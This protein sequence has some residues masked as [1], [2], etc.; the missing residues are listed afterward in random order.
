[1]KTMRAVLLSFTLL[2]AAGVQAADYLWEVSS[3]TNRIY[4][5]GTVH[6]GKKEWYPLTPE[7][8]KAF[9]DSK[10]L[11]V[12][13]DIL[14]TNAMRKSAAASTYKP[15]DSL[16]EHVAAADYARLESILPRFGIGEHELD[17]MKPFMAVSV[18]VFYEWARLGFTPNFGVD[19]YFLRKAKAELKPVVELEGIDA[20]IKLIDSLSDEENRLL[21]EGTITALESGLTDRQIVGMV[22]AWKDGDP[23]AM[24]E[25][26][27]K[28]NDD[29][30]GAQEFEE[31]FVW[32]RHDAMAAKIEG[33]LNR[34]HEPYF[35]AV[36]ALH[37]AGPRGL[38]EILRKRGYLVKQMGVA[39][40]ETE[41]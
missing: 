36:G 25:V 40:S 29:V 37:L 39:P 35:V 4:L 19:A 13:A 20:Q 41:K 18:L 26:A 21:F 9:D 17:A 11:A 38:V 6:A 10:A 24:L 27:R 5:F 8:E 2:A 32:S 7:V 30:A 22:N 1:M 3:L 31:K 28:Y 23:D 16:K 15:P 34:T 14:D 12:E 33:F